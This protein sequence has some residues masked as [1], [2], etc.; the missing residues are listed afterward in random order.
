MSKR[1]LVGHVHGMSHD[2]MVLSGV[3][4]LRVHIL[5]SVKQCLVGC[6]LRV[7]ANACVAFLWQLVLRLFM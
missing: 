6:A 3:W 5:I 1:S 2:G 4:S 7:L